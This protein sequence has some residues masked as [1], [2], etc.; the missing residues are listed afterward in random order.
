MLQKY[1]TYAY[2]KFPKCVS[3]S[4]ANAITSTSISVKIQKVSPSM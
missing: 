2:A 4:L 1:N 3:T